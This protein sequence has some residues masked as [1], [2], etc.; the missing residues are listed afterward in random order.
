[1]H[2][3]KTLSKTSHRM[4]IRLLSASAIL[5]LAMAAQAAPAGHAR[6]TERQRHSSGAESEKLKRLIDDYWENTLAD[7]P[8]WAT[9]TG[10]HRFDD[11]LPDVSEAAYR[12]RYAVARAFLRRA[13]RIK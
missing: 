5:W 4:L 7:Y 13:D 9:H 12:A 1:M 8:D 6:G 3:P 2:F 10:D 11:K